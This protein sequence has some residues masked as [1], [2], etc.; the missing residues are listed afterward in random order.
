LPATAPA[1][2]TTTGEAA[3]LIATLFAPKPE[4]PENAPAP[5]SPETEDEA[6]DATPEP[7]DEEG[8]TAPPE[9]DTDADEEPAEEAPPEIPDHAT[10]TV[11]VDGKT[12]KVTGKELREGYSRHADYT[13]KSQ[14]VAEQRRAVEAERVQTQAER[15]SLQEALT[16]VKAS[17]DAQAPKRPDVSLH[18]TDPVEFAYQSEVFNRHREQVQQVT[19]AQ[20][21]LSQRTAADQARAQQEYLRAEHGKLLEVIPDW[22]DEKVAAKEQAAITAFAKRNGYSDEDLS[23]V[24]DHRAVNILRKAMRYEQLMADKKPLVPTPLKLVTPTLKPGQGQTE[25]KAT[26]SK[27]AIERATQSGRV[28]D[29]ADAILKAGLF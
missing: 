21:E 4:E 8:D 10:T 19:A 25:G 12:L 6:P 14:A 17:L 15:Q 2:G 26:R 23:A 7:S 13:A 5:E 20:Q 18:E 11:K 3:S 24:T 16:Q 22:K 9:A 1:I 29:A 27:A 28:N